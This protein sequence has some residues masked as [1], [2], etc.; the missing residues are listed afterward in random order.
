MKRVIYCFFV[1]AFFLAV[2]CACQTTPPDRK[3]LLSTPFCAE[4]KGEVRG[5]EFVA[6]IEGE[7]KD[8]EVL[9]SYLS[10]DPLSG[11]YVRAHLDA[12]GSL[13][14]RVE[15]GQGETKA[16]L[17]RAGAEGLLLPFSTLLSHV[18]EDAA[19]LQK[20]ERGGYCFTFADGTRLSVSEE[21]IPQALTSSE[22][23]YQ[24]VWWEE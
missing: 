2:T 5:V 15:V 16:E 7:G 8:G 18:Q 20:E 19:S 10:P 24:I 22:L 1:L 9:I 21:G 11:L 17:P 13:G 23:S 4:I 12:G 14:E 3:K 6:K